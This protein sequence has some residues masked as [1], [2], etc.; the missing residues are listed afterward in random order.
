VDLIEATRRY[1]TDAKYHASVDTIVMA[2]VQVLQD[3]PTTRGRDPLQEAFH[4]E[5]ANHL[6]GWDDH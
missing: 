6:L 2:A 1:H 4:E 3:L 5:V